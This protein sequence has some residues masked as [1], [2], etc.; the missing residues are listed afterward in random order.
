MRKMPWEFD[1]AACTQ[2][3]VELFFSKD[4]DDPEKIGFP[5]DHY[6]Q[7]KKVCNTCTHQ[8]DCALWG[9]EN[10]AHGMWGGMT[11]KE[12]KMAKR[13]GKARA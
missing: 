9:M 2:V 8:I 3:G 7:A 1:Q 10:E 13:R 4:Y 12:R 5:S 11:P 6:Q